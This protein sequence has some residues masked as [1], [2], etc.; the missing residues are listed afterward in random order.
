MLGHVYTGRAG[1][2]TTS[3]LLV[4]G[5]AERGGWVGGP[6]LPGVVLGSRGGVRLPGCISWVAAFPEHSVCV[7]TR[8]RGVCVQVESGSELWSRRLGGRSAAGPALQTPAVLPA[9]VTTG[10]PISAGVPGERAVTPRGPRAGGPQVCRGAGRLCGVP[11]L[12]QPILSPLSLGPW[13]RQAGTQA[14]R[15]ARVPQ[16]QTPSGEGPRPHGG[17]GGAR[18]EP[19]CLYCDVFAR[20]PLRGKRRVALFWEPVTYRRLYLVPSRLVTP[21]GTQG[22]TV[23]AH[24]RLGL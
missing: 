10:T 4:P 8:L 13:A 18:S 5:A 22:S 11:W 21:G 7:E 19:A 9:A 23:C 14:L 17:P 6:S 3:A 20:G 24:G 12:G 16:E 1:R 15:C 2:P